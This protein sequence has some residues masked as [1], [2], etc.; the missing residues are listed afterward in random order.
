MSSSKSELRSVAEWKLKQKRKSRL[1]SKSRMR[2]RSKLGVKSTLESIVLTEPK[3]EAA[4]RPKFKCNLSCIVRGGLDAS[5][6][7]V[8]SEDETCVTID[9]FP[10]ELEH[11]SPE[12]YGNTRDL[13]SNCNVENK[14]EEDQSAMQPSL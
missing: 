5:V 8:V 11:A 7:D 10:K 4:P 13:R 1:G 12:T 9:V 3:R 6:A 14:V 2:P